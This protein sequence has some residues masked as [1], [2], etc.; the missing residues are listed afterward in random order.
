MWRT[1]AG[2][3]GGFATAWICRSLLGTKK[4]TPPVAG[5]PVVRPREL[6]ERQRRE[7][8]EEPTPVGARSAGNGA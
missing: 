4:Q 6:S 8:G 2:F 5:E 7:M 3:L 1:I